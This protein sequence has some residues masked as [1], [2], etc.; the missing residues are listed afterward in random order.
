MTSFR[1]KLSTLGQVPNFTELDRKYFV[2]LPG[3]IGTK[4]LGAWRKGKTPSYGLLTSF[5]AHLQ[6][7]IR[8]NTDAPWAVDKTSLARMGGI[9]AKIEAYIKQVY[10]QGKTKSVRKLTPVQMELQAILED[11]VEYASDAKGLAS[12]LTKL[13]AIQFASDLLEAANFGRFDRPLFEMFPSTE[14]VSYSYPLVS[15]YNVH[16]RYNPL[17]FIVALVQAVGYSPAKAKKLAK[18]WA[19]MLA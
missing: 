7:L 5:V 8:V 13:E 4:I 18:A 3:G 9:I 6:E 2:N 1:Q 12:Q 16:T 10:P 11:A 15:K 17:G 14:E 19:Q